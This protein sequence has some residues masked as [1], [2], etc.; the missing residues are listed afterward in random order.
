M[1]LVQTANKRY[2]LMAFRFFRVTS[3]PAPR[4]F[5]AWTC[6]LLIIKFFRHSTNYFFKVREV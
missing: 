3:M 4:V 6:V 5:S 1:S 2:L